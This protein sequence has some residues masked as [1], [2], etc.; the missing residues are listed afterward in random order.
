MSQEDCGISEILCSSYVR[1]LRDREKPEIL[2]QEETMYF[3]LKKTYP[4][5]EWITTPHTA[6][7]QLQEHPE[8][9]VRA[10]NLGIDPGTTLQL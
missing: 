5:M 9:G 8:H 7:G 2:L 3:I 10:D 1:A 4:E 6:V